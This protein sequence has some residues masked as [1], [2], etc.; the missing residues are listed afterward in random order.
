MAVAHVS[1]Y[2][3]EAAA[4]QRYMIASSNYSYQQ[5]CDVI[6]EKFPALRD[7]TPR[8][9]PGSPLPPVYALDTSKAVKDLGFAPRSLEETMTDAVTS[10]L[11]LEEKLRN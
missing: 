3:K 6:R 9:S 5:I 1:A 2:E 10:L 4:N 7:L 11:A 8:G